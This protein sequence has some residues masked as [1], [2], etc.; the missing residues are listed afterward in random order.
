MTTYFDV[1]RFP[2][3]PATVADV[4]GGAAPVTGEHDAVLDLVQLL[5]QFVEEGS[6]A[7]HVAIAVPEHPLLLA[8][9]VGVGGVD[10]EVELVSLAHKVLLPAAEGAAVPGGHRPVVDRLGGVGNDLVFVDAHRPAEAF[11]LRAGTVGVVVIEQGGGGLEEGHAVEFE[12]V[13][14]GR[15]VVGVEPDDH[16]A[17]A[18]GKGRTHRVGDPLVVLLVVGAHHEAVD[19]HHHL[20][21]VVQFGQGFAEYGLVRFQ[22]VLD[23]RDRIVL[24]HPGVA[25][26]QQ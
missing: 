17:A 5:T 6:D 19:E 26:L 4:A 1:L 13:V 25:L 3:Q 7:P 2:P 23:L 22:D 16:L 20:V 10:G 12:A 21:L 9:K 14:P 18:F 24:H 8:G 15:P 11:A